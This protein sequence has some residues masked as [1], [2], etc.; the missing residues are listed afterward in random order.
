MQ[1]RI[2]S[3][4]PAIQTLVTVLDTGSLTEA[5]GRLGLTPSG[6]SKQL[7]RL[8]EHLGI[9]LLE[10]T[11]RKVRATRAGLELCQ[12]AKPLFESFEDAGRAIV[13]AERSISGRVRLSAAP[14][15]GRTV[16]LPTLHALSKKHPDLRFDVVLTGRRL[17]FVDNDIDLAIREGGLEDSTLIA[18]SIATV[19]VGLYAAREYLARRGT[20]RSLVELGRHDIVA[21]PTPPIGL[22]LSSEARALGLAPKF[23]VDD[24]FAVAELAESGAGIAPLPDYVARKRRALKR[25]L[26]RVELASFP[27]HAV[28]PSRRHLPRRVQVVIEALT[29]S[30]KASK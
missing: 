11:T 3:Q 30:A 13:D 4:L 9:R 25:V 2:V 10:R 16:V 12:R 6:V 17:D 15:Y 14:S 29:G 22:G 1:S 7:A 28:Y 26:A 19:S 27:I 23:R 18:R 8:E 24:L 21:I 5:A 20:P